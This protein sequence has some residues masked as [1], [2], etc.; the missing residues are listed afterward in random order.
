M[1][2]DLM[3]TKGVSQLKLSTVTSKACEISQGPSC[4]MHE[5]LHSRLGIGKADLSSLRSS[6]HLGAS[7]S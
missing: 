4:Q 7:S 5:Q 2:K 3:K 1:A 6:N